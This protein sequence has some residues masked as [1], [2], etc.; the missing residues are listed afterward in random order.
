M[1]IYDEWTTAEKRGAE[2]EREEIVEMLEGRSQTA[3]MTADESYNK[4]VQNG[5]REALALVKARGGEKSG[6]I[7]RLPRQMD[8]KAATVAMMDKIDELADAV[9]EMRR[10]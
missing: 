8:W 10:A 5:V 1:Y 3:P 2:R 4:G 7:D 6:K 9:N